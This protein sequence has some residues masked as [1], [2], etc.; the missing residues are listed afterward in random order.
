LLDVVLGSLHQHDLRLFQRLWDCLKAG[1]ILLGDRA[2]GDYVT[3]AGLP[4]QGVDVVARLHQARKV[5]SRRAKRMANIRSGLEAG[6]AGM[7]AADGITMVLGVHGSEK[8][9]GRLVL[10]FLLPAAPFPEPAVAAAPEQAQAAHPLGSA[11]PALVVAIGH[12][13]ALVQAGFDAAGGPAGGQPLGGV[14]FGGRQ[15]RHQGH[16][17]RAVL[18]QAPVQEGDLFDARTIHF[19]G[20]GGCGPRGRVLA[21]SA[22]SGGLS[23]SAARQ[24]RARA[25]K[26]RMAALRW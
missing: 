1:D 20:E 10:R 14:E 24:R 23:R 18:A 19:F 2:Y 25:R 9:G 21:L 6:V 15:V 12:V 22:A 13:Q 4:R 11:H 8:V 7:A 26:A 5:D 3:P 16:G 17:L